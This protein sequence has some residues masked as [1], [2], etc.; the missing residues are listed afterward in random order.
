MFHLWRS[1]R[2]YADIALVLTPP[3]DRGGLSHFSEYNIIE[4]CILSGDDVDVN[5]IPE[6]RCQPQNLITRSSSQTHLSLELSITFNVPKA[7]SGEDNPLPV[8]DYC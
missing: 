8:C 2:F 7:I 5:L 4:Y 1:L 3:S 6:S